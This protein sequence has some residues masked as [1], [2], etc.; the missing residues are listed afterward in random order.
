MLFDEHC[1][2]AIAKVLI[3]ASAVIDPIS[4]SPSSRVTYYYDFQ[5][6]AHRPFW[7]HRVKRGLPLMNPN[8]LLILIVTHI[9]SLSSDAIR[10]S[11]TESSGFM[12]AALH[13]IR[14]IIVTQICSLSS[15]AFVSCTNA[16][17][18]V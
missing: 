16:D 6:S 1:C 11:F 8:I 14:S 15:G 17:G 7:Y 3:P 12:W 2:T 18:F 5:N 13:D 10:I 4:F 9:C